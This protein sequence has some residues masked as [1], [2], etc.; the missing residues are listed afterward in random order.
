MPATQ[1]AW[2]G[3]GANL[4]PAQANVVAAIERLR[5]W[6][7]DAGGFAVSSLYRS[8]P[9]DAAGPDYINAVAVFKTALPAPELLAA[10]QG[11]EAEFDRA[12]PYRN[13]PRTLDLDL[14]L[15][16]DLVCSDAALCLP[17]PRL[18]RRAFVLLPMLELA[19]ELEAPGLG[20]LSN[21]LAGVA[22]QGI[23]RMAS[24]APCGAPCG[25]ST[26]PPTMP[27]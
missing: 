14:L 6:A 9:V 22:D 15:Y 5:A 20:R 19:P 1:R 21:H 3:L 16:G 25:A 10:L 18:H 8:T 13:A 7:G 27:R 12:R 23:T 11:V 24:G 26:P 4:G 17:H 2:V